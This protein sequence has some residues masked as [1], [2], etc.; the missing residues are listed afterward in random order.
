MLTA[1]ATSVNIQIRAL[2]CYN[3][4]TE[5]EEMRRVIFYSC[6]GTLTFLAGV[7]IAS[8]RLVRSTPSVAPPSVSI[9]ANPQESPF[10]LRMIF[11]D[12]DFV[13][14]GT[15][16]PITAPIHGLSESL[17]FPEKFEAGHK[18]VFHR[19]GSTDTDLLFE[20]L[21]NRFRSF[22]LETELS[23]DVS[24]GQL[25]P[26]YLSFQ[27][28]GFKGY[29]QMCLHKQISNNGESKYLTDVFDYILILC[30]RP[31]NSS[32]RRLNQKQKR[33]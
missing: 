22:D 14:G 25:H 31:V 21:Q 24:L 10:D 29:I 16:N 18:Y 8:L 33:G 30:A 15:S 7:S 26:D 11:M 20:A 19:R 17:P 2:G 4:F 3:L 6:V 23:G 28:K 13:G 27:G 1:K 32:V 12:F 5:G 9:A